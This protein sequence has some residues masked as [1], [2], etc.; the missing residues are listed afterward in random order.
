MKKLELFEEAVK[1][2]QMLE[3]YS[4]KIL[5]EESLKTD[6]TATITK[7]T[8]DR[9]DAELK[10]HPDQMKDFVKGSLI[11]SISA[12]EILSIGILHE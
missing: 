2:L 9:V 12:S 3:E 7:N 4:R 10:D 8:F 5:V 1:T 6:D 11:T